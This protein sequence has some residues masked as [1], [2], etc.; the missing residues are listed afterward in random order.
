MNIKEDIYTCTV[1]PIMAYPEYRADLDVSYRSSAYPGSFFAWCTEHQ[2][3]I[4]QYLEG[5]RS[6]L[7]VGPHYGDI[8]C[9][10]MRHFLPNLEEYSAIEPN[11]ENF[12]K[13]LSTVG[14]AMAERPGVSTHFYL[15]DANDWAGMGHQVDV[16]LCLG[17]LQY[18]RDVEGFLRTCQGWLRPGGM[19]WVMV[20]DTHAIFPSLAQLFDLSSSSL[21]HT[22]DIL[23]RLDFQNVLP[24][25]YQFDLKDVGKVF[26]RL[27]LLREPTAQDT[28]KY[29]HFVHQ[30]YAKEHFVHRFNR[31]V[32]ICKNYN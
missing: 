22:G 1:Y 28:A 8:D 2:V 4:S 12:S 9:F 32:F 23:K 10:I 20:S 27:A 6:C 26:L 29:Q 30:Q 15:E 3:E 16:I 18:M 17:V 25:E 14:S 21:T 11:L 5:A 13:P 24:Y 7:S 19:L 31:R